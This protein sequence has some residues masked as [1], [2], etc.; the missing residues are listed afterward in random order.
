MTVTSFFYVDNKPVK[1]ESDL[2]ILFRFVWYATLLDVNREVN[3]GRG[4][5]DYKVS[6]GSKDA[7]LVEFK[8]ASNTSLK[9]NLEKQLEIY[10]KANNTQFGIKVIMYFNDEELN[11]VNKVLKELNMAEDPNVVLIDARKKKSASK[12]DGN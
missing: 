9:R 3:N 5:V 6:R 7:T 4:P 12:E 2:Q 10:Q 8:L 1:R 11:R